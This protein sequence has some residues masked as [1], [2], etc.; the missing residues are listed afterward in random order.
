MMFR[1]SMLINGILC[2]IESVYGL[3]NAHIE[4]LELCDRILMRKIFNSVST[5][6][7]EAYYLESNTLPLRFVVLARRLMYYWGILKKT[8]TELV[9]KVFRAQQLSPVKNDWCL[10]IKEDLAYLDIDKDESEISAMTK[11]KFKKYLNIKIK[12][13]AQKYLSSLKNKHTKSEGL[14]VTDQMQSYLISSKLSLSEKQLM[15]QFRTR[16]YRCRANYKNQYGSNLAC[17][18]CG[19]EDDQIHLLQCKKTTVGVDLDGVQY[20]DIFSS[21]DKQVKIGKVLKKIT[22]NREIIMKTSSTTG[23]QVH[24]C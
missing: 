15:F 18:I 11:L 20:C 2:S 12:D 13:A 5:T 6:A 19:E 9:K 3:T 8:E 21:I 1:N 23:S 14:S 7:I 22:S 4:Q 16:T 24:P 17:L 10:K